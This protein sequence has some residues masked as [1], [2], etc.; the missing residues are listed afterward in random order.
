MIGWGEEGE[1]HKAEEEED[2]EEEGEGVVLITGNVCS[3]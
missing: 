3:S 1:A 2:K